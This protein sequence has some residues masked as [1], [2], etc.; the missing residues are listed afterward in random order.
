MEEWHIGLIFVIIGVILLILEATSPGF[1]I[2]IPAT[3][4][5]VLGLIG[6]VVPN[7]FLSPLSPI[8]A[9]VVTIP[10]T[11]LTMK[12]YQRLSPPSPPT[13]TVGYSLIGKQGI[14]EVPIVPNTIRGKVKIENQVW[15]A[16][17]DHP[18]EKG[19]LV[20]IVQSRGV[21]VVVRE[22]Q[23]ASPRPADQSLGG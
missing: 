7:F 18:I 22:V 17:S 21:H 3:V 12:L 6:M 2:A 14:V 19:T 23:Q 8:V 15:S 16:T 9:L 5:L 1:F 11:I 4:L 13:T 20:E 10:A